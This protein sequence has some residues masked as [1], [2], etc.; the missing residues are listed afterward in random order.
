VKQIFYNN[1][2][3][4]LVR[5]RG[6]TVELFSSDCQIHNVPKAQLDYSTLVQNEKPLVPGRP[7]LPDRPSDWLTK[8]REE[9]LRIVAQNIKTRKVEKSTGGEKTPKVRKPKASSDEQ[10]MARM[11]EAMRKKMLGGAA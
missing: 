7:L 5:E 6:E 8:W 3:M 1:Q 9:R 10:L 11:A 4:T 2:Q